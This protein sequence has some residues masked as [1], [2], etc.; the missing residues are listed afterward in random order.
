MF[1]IVY[2]YVNGDD[3]THI[4]SKQQAMN[5]FAPEPE[6]S[7]ICRFHSSCEIVFSLFSIFMF[8]N[9]EELSKIYVVIS[10][11]SNQTISFE[12]PTWI[13]NH[14][15]FQAFLNER[16]EYV[17]H[18][19]IIPI[20]FLPTFNSH[21]IELYL[22]NIP[23]LLETFVYFNDDCFLGAPVSQSFFFS[24]SE[25]KHTRTNEASS[26]FSPSF[27]ATPPAFQANI[28]PSTAPM[29]I[30]TGGLKNQP[31]KTTTMF[32]SIMNKTFDL[33]QTRF[34]ALRT[35]KAQWNKCHHQAKALLKSSCQA[36]HK[37]TVFTKIIAQLSARKFRSRQDFSPIELI[38]GYMYFTGK[39][40]TLDAKPYTFY[41]EWTQDKDSMQ[42]KFDFLLKKTPSPLLICI[43]DIPFESKNQTTSSTPMADRR[44]QMQSRRTKQ[45]APPED[46]SWKVRALS[47]FAHEY[48]RKSSSRETQ[49]A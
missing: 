15:E 16:L 1:D 33:L 32:Q 5:V 36:V 18:S 6:S 31:Q 7:H 41:I 23:N 3:P 10:D 25:E 12:H 2:T 8:V 24:Q 34:V 30:T 45:A 47:Y 27:Q 14:T 28:F 40:I 48:F 19:E 42:T 29:K 37:D 46:L 26:P 22:N 49:S 35:A 17:R 21:V 39:G 20:E 38:I 11:N 9:H 44:L 4:Q 43:N 13:Q